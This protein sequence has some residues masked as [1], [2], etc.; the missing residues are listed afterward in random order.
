MNTKIAP[1]AICNAADSSCL[2]DTSAEAKAYGD[3]QYYMSFGGD[4][5]FDLN[6]AIDAI[7][8]STGIL[9]QTGHW[10]SQMSY[11]VAGY[12]AIGEI[13]SFTLLHPNFVPICQSRRHDNLSLIR[14]YQI[15]FTSENFVWENN[16]SDDQD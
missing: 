8:G 10:M 9:I 12:T 15:L 1:L 4:Q 14:L 13:C 3:Y 16:E 11:E 6:R 5:Y 2:A 7:Y